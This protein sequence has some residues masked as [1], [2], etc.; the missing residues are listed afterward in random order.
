M[1]RDPT[2][3]Q[4][5]NAIGCNKILSLTFSIAIGAAI[6]ITLQTLLFSYDQIQSMLSCNNQLHEANMLPPDD[7][8]RYKKGN[9]SISVAAI[10]I[11]S[12]VAD[13]AAKDDDDVS[14]DE[15]EEPFNQTAFD[16]A[17]PIPG[18][19]FI[20]NTNIVWLLSF[21]NSGTSYTLQLIA[22]VT[23][24]TTA[25]N[26]PAEPRGE[27]LPLLRLVPDS[28]T[29]IGPYPLHVFKPIPKYTLT[30]AHCFG[31]STPSPPSKYVNISLDA[32]DERC[33]SITVRHDDDEETHTPYSTKTPV[34]AVH[35]VR[36]PFDNMVSRWHLFNK[37]HDDSYENFEDFCEYWDGRNERK[38]A[39][40]YI[41][42]DLWS[43]MK[44]LPCQADWYRW[45]QWHN[46]AFQLAERYNFPVLYINY[47]D[48]GTNQDGVLQ[49]LLN[50]LELPKK[51]EPTPFHKG[52]SYLDEFS[53]DEQQKAKQFVEYFAS[54]KTW[55]F[56][57]RYFQHIKA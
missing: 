10:A 1:A 22:E 32:F 46:L 44:G 3:K 4:T 38:R 39:E 31:Y 34:K 27:G 43:L 7:N 13:D 24:T 50:F 35:I 29:T 5:H 49:D 53:R 54:E 19:P 40:D 47:E 57:K 36:N 28:N 30:K 51:N 18:T 45:V 8:F 20:A 16:L 14:S 25:T 55:A 2:Q 15:E 12:A 42:Q 52:K 33:R 11:A 41:P 26:Y 6:G 21:P 17:H 9:A 23:D 56:V 37:D 48:Y